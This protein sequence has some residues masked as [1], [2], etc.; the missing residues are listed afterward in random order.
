MA[1]TVQSALSQA[2]RPPP[3]LFHDW[4]CC[5][6]TNLT[7]EKEY[8]VKKLIAV[9]LVLAFAAPAFAAGPIATS[10][11]RAAGQLAKA[12]ETTRRAN[13]Y[14]WPSVGMMGGGATL[15][16]IGFLRTTGAEVNVGNCNYYDTSNTSCS[17]P[18]K[19]KH[20]T[21]LAIA[22]LGVAG[23]G[24]ALMMIGE[25]KRGKPLADVSFGPGQFKVSKQI[26]F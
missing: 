25:G 9:L 5:T 18:A 3:C 13:P 4:H 7:S 20:N 2:T 11:A 21:G 10:A 19:E 1:R 15:A 24:V 22:G 12:P 8:K 23:A 6:H 16:A 26:K 14:L 17:I